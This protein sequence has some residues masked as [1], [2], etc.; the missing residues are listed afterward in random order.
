MKTIIEKRLFWFLKEG[1]ELDLS[2]KAQLD[3]YVQQ[4]LTRGKTS[5]IKRLF[6]IIVP[7]VFHDSFTRIKSFLPKEVK[8]FWEE[9][10][11]DS[12]QSAK[13]DTRSL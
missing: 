1:T 8:R 4:V 7:S 13:K 12:H 2:D 3:M 10:I 6:R 11:G 5:D 9:D